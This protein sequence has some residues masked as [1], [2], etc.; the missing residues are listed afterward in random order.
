MK[1]L[2]FDIETVPTEQALESR[3]L[4]E[5]QMQLDE[6]ELVKKLSLSAA[7]AKILCIG[8]AVEPPADSPARILDGDEREILRE[9]WRLAFETNLFVGH[10]ILDFDLRFIYQR[11]VIHQIKPSRD[12]PFARYRSAPVFDTM[13]EWSRWGREHVSLDVLARALDIPSP[14]EGLDGSKVYPYFRAGR[15]AEICEYCKRDVESVRQVYR[16]LTFAS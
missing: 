1:I 12:I 9:F 3:G 11:S 10:N 5:P 2:F 6:A 16:R 8:Y 7:T 4:L 15:L 13:H 14:K